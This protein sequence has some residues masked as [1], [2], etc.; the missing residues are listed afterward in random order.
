LLTL[1]ALLTS[2]ALF[3]LVDALLLLV[4][5]L[6]LTL[7]VLGFPLR[8]SIEFVA[9]HL[10]SELLTLAVLGCHFEAL[11]DRGCGGIVCSV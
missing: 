5:L 3:D 6:N 7:H 9:N 4:L 8:G 10:E 1:S 2:L 11:L